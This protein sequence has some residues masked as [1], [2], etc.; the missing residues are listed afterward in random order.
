[1]KKILALVMALCMLCG[2]AVAEEAEATYTYNTYMSEFPTVWSP[3]QMQT[4][5]DSELSD[6]LTDGFYG[7]DFNETYDGYV[8]VPRMATE[9]PVDVTADYVGEK[10]G[11]AEGETGR[12]WKISLRDDLKWQDG[13][14]ISAADFV[15]SAQ[16]LLNPKA[17]NYRADSY[18]SGQLV[19][20]NAQGYA[21][22][23]REV[24]YQENNTNGERFVVADFTK[25]EDGVY[26]TNQ[27]K[28][29]YIAVKAG[30]SDWLSGNSL[31]KYVNAYGDA[32]FGMENWEALAGAANEDGY[33]A[34]TDE[35]MGW[36]VSVI[37]TNPNWGESEANVP[38][39]LAYDYVNP[40]VEWDNV[41]FLATGDNEITL[42]LDKALEGFY[43]HYNLTGSYLVNIP[44]YESLIV[45]TDG[46]FTNAYG[47]SLET[48]FSYG[49]WMLTKYQSDKEIELVKNPYWYG[50]ALP[51][52]E[53]LYQTTCIHYDC[54]EQPETAYEM[55]FA[56]KLDAK[57]LDKDHMADYI[58]SEYTYLSEGDSVFAMVFN[59]DLEA[60]T[61]N[62][63]AAGEN[64]NK[65]ILTVKEFRMA[66]SFAMD[67]QA[68][69]LATSPMNAPA[70]ALYSGQIVS[71]P[72][73]GEFYRTTEEAKD[74]IVNFWALNDD[75]G[76]D[77]LYADKDEAIDA[78]TG[79]NLAQAKEYFDK[80][81]DIAIAEG[82]MDE[83]DV[84]T[85]IVGTPN[86]TAAFYN[87]GYD[88]IVN[89]YTEAVKGTK[90][91]G[92]I[93]F[94]RDS[95]LGNGFS[96]AL[97]ANTVDMLFGVGWTGSTFDPYG[98]MEAYTSSGYQYDPSWDTTASKLTIELDGVKYTASV[99]DWTTSMTGAA[100][101]AEFEGALEVEGKGTVTKGTITLDPAVTT[102]NKLILAALE[103]AVLQNYDFIPLMGD[104]GAALKGMQIE[105]FLEDEVFPMGRGGIKYMTY[106]MTDA[107]WDAFVVEQGGIL[108][109]K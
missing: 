65:T 52:N 46:V 90:L 23:G 63:K 64:V 41:G 89:N 10:W 38:D 60:L 84:V 66:M 20:K 97:K 81:Y 83:D 13:T 78:L 93:A 73:L 32:N 75:I 88:F 7:F 49:P 100:I 21:Y 37:A 34:L 42:V 76:E 101:E 104:S 18:Y 80:A 15:K 61:E 56:G 74:V 95:T 25:G 11:I 48:S 51:E 72:E 99:W 103:N 31:E 70:F 4:A 16:Y 19:I 2:V 62:Q 3:F 106:N 85:I 5:T 24:S 58:D 14:A 102:S 40:T 68:F 53:G 1:M 44:L 43:L 8:M 82:L 9:F 33:V 39:Y 29:V 105:Y 91:E 67:R 30:L 109:Y 87:S 35:T 27:G 96:D 45:E 47:T 12:A 57:G 107:E 71:D 77:K 26:L 6:Y 98:L 94:T 36:L 86:A 79:Y 92:K 22:S 69:C 50:Y 59:P 17:A 54:I 55:F 108:N 28:V